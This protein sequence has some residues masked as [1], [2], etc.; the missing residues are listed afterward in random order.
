MCTADAMQWQL[1]SVSPQSYHQCASG[2]VNECHPGRKQCVCVLSY[3]EVCILVAT[4]M[5]IQAV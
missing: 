4:S 3:W 2:V 5:L 1:F